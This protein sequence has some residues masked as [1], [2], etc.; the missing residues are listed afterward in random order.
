MTGSTPPVSEVLR[1]I[2]AI[3]AHSS[4]LLAEALRLIEQATKAEIAA[5]ETAVAALGESHA[6]TV[7]E[8]AR[9]S[10]SSET[11]RTARAIRA[12]AD[13]FLGRSASHSP[14][15]AMP[16]PVTS[17]ME[18]RQRT[19]P[20]PH[21][22]ASGRIS[23]YGISV[24]A[25]RVEE[26]EDVISAARIAVARNHKANRYE[27]YR[28]KNSW[29]KSLF[30]AAF[31]VISDEEALRIAKELSDAAAPQVVAETVPAAP[32]P[33]EPPL[34]RPSIAGAGPVRAARPSISASARP[35]VSPAVPPS[36]PADAL[37]SRRHAHGITAQTI[38]IE[39]VSDPSSKRDPASPPAPAGRSS[40]FNKRT[41]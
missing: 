32:P 6:R 25:G 2:E 31:S 16:G 40:F 20:A 36:R 7:V 4:E 24:P 10:V 30:L 12:A 14:S 17:E 23:I 15:T 35:A 18:P 5:M 37:S 41:R 11:G 27:N 33:S 21:P 22:D 34:T 9:M 3:A 39:T 8:L 1:G 13:A 38:D 19:I 28:G 26:A 29:C